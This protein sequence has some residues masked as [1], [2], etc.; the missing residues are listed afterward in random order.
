MNIIFAKHENNGKEFCFEVLDEQAGYIKKGD[1]LLVETCRGNA[2]ATATTDV[3]SGS[4]AKD[5]ANKSGASFPLKKVISF[6]DSTLKEYIH[7]A[8]KESVIKE[9]DSRYRLI[10]ESILNEL[11]SK[12][13]DMKNS[14]LNSVRLVFDDDLPF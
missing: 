3:I 11:D 7:N 2:A 8:V 6:V 10:K 4:G 1:L 12:Y 13:E 14:V 5:V 9:L